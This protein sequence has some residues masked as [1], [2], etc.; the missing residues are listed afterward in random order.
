MSRGRAACDHLHLL[1]RTALL[2][3]AF[4]ATQRG[5]ERKRE[6]ERESSDVESGARGT[7]DAENEQERESAV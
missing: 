4:Y 1:K 7:D 2:T 6:R 3:K 5:R